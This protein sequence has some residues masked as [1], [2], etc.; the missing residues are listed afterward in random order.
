[1]F[2]LD[3]FEI[4]LIGIAAFA[5][6]AVNSVAGGGTPTASRAGK[7]KKVPPPATEFTAPAAKAAMPI[8]AIS[9]RSRPNMGVSALQGAGD[10]TGRPDDRRLQADGGA[11]A[12]ED[13]A[14]RGAAF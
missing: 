5:A 13:W 11:A 6:G 12:T 4:A 9:N 1:M 7:E 8:R 3:L 2:G 10:G 14:F